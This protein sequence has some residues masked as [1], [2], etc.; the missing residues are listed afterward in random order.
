MRLTGRY[1]TIL[2]IILML[3]VARVVAHSMSSKAPFIEAPVLKASLIPF[4]ERYVARVPQDYPTIQAAVDAVAEGGTVLIGPG[5]YKENLIVTKSLRLVGAG[6]ER[7]QIQYSD[8]NS[9]IIDFLPGT[10]ITL[11]I[12]IQDLT[13]GDPTFPIEQVVDPPTPTSPRL[14]G[15]GLSIFAPVQ[16]VLR[17]VI[18]AGLAAGVSGLASYYGFFSSQIILEEVSLARNGVGLS[19]VGAQIFTFRSQIEENIVGITAS[20]L[21]LLTQS[22]VSKNRNIG[23]IFAISGIS[24]PKLIGHIRDNEFRQNGIGISLAAG[25]EGHRILIQENRFVQNEKYGIVIQDPACPISPLLPSPPKS[26]LIQV[27]GGSNEFYNNSQDL[28]PADYP[29]P[30]GFRK[31]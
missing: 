1:I 29:W 10:A 2:V 5:I 30:P 23:I 15:K 27:E 3:G 16:I 4:Q 22:S 17:R 25:R 28:C 11:Q 19:L 18:I 20:D 6:Q 26:A 21:L 9:P 13:I 31:P 8:P 24:E 7:V 12:H 14:T